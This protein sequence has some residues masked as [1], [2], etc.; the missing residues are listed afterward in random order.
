MNFELPYCTS[1]INNSKHSK[2]SIN[3]GESESH[4][5]AMGY[6]R[7]VLFIDCNN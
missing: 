4:K 5:M 7:L 6:Y 1:K 3:A 2:I